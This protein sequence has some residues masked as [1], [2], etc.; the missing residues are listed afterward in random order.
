MRTM[1][2]GAGKGQKGMM[3]N[4]KGT[5][6]GGLANMNPHNMQMNA[7]QMAR[8]LPPQVRACLPAYMTSPTDDCISD[9]VHAAA[10]GSKHVFMQSLLLELACWCAAWA[11]SGPV[12]SGHAA[13][14]TQTS[15][16]SMLNVWI[17]AGAEANGRRTGPVGAH[18]ADGGHEVSGR[19][20]ERQV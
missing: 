16:R 7:S 3:Q 18:E 10:S 11:A 4:M 14:D 12:M 6:G 17:C 13:T 1:L 8:M 15:L 19:G 20:A 5:K 9:G 2:V